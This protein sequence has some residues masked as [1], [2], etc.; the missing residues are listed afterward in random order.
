MHTVDTPTIEKLD[1][2][3]TDDGVSLE[4]Q[5]HLP[6]NLIFFQGHFPEAAILPGI[7]QLHW[8]MNFSKEQGIHL[9]FDSVDRLKFMRPI[10]PNTQVVLSIQFLEKTQQLV[11]TYRS[12][13]QK[14]STGRI[15]LKPRHV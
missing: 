9:A 14:C 4:Y 12:Q 7:A 6:E 8:V 3:D 1:R 5:L 10:V 11:F 13:G 2:H 15:A